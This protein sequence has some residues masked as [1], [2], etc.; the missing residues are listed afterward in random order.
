MAAVLLMVLLLPLGRKQAARRKPSPHRC[1]CP[2]V[3]HEHVCEPTEDGVAF[4]HV[5][6]IAVVLCPETWLLTSPWNAKLVTK[7]LDVVFVRIR[8]R[9][10]GLAI[11]WGG[12]ATE[13]CKTGQAMHFSRIVGG[14][15]LDKC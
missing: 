3:V 11:V 9:A 1:T 7:L 15:N 13:A 10:A 5:G 14:L 4:V 6:L 2:E 8:V 12:C